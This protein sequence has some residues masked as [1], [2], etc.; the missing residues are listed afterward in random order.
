MFRKLIKD[1]FTWYLVVSIGLLYLLAIHELESFSDLGES[2]DL[3]LLSLQRLVFLGSIGIAAWHFNNRTG[4]IIFLTGLPALIWHSTMHSHEETLFSVLLELL[5]VVGAAMVIL[6]TIV[7]WQ[8]SG[9]K[10][11]VSEERYRITAEQTGIIVYDYDVPSGRIAWQGAIEAITGFTPIEFAEVDIHRW[12]TLVHPDDLQHTLDELERSRREC[13]AFH[14]EYRFRRKDD[15]Y[16]VIEESGLFLPG[17]DGLSQRMVGSMSDIT[18][19]HQAAQALERNLEL[20]NVISRLLNRSLQPGS[21]HELLDDAL[22]MLLSLPWLAAENRGAIFL[23]E[24]DPPML[25]L[26]SRHG[27][28]EEIQEFCLKVPYGHCLCGRTALSG[29]IFFS[30]DDV[31]PENIK[32]SAEP[33]GHYCVPIIYKEKV[34][35]V[36]TIYLQPGHVRNADEELFLKTVADTLANIIHAHNIM[37]EDDFH[38]NIL[39]NVRDSIIVTDNR[40]QITYWNQGAENIFGYTAT[41]MIGQMTTVLY[42]ELDMERFESG[43]EKIRQG[44]VFNEEWCGKRK[45]GT[46]VWVNVR[47][48][49]LI[50]AGKSSGGFIAVAQDISERKNAEQALQTSRERLLDAQRIAHLGNWDWDIVNDTLYWSDEIYRIFGLESGQSEPN[51]RDFLKVVHPDDRK[52]VNTAV[53]DAVKRKTPYD[54]DHRIVRPDGRVQFVHEQ[55]EVV[56]SPEGVALRMSGT[57]QDITERKQTERELQRLA[58][59]PLFSPIPILE[60]TREG[61]LSY[62]NPTTTEMFPDITLNSRSHPVIQAMLE[63]LSYL[64]GI[65]NKWVMFDVM[66][67]N[68][69]Y[70]VYVIY[71]TS[72]AHIRGYIVDITIHRQSMLL[73]TEARAAELAS[74]AKSD[75]L[76]S[77]SHEL[78]TP[79]NAIIGF[80]QVLQEEYFG[81][82]NPQQKEYLNDILS[83]G[84]HLM[85]LINDILDLSKVEAGK[86]ELEYSTV[87]LGELLDHSMVVIREKARVHTITLE[88]DIPP[89][90]ADKEIRVDERRIRQVIF[91]LLSNAA[92]FTPDGGRITLS[93]RINRHQLTV[94]VA[95]T[96]IGIEPEFHQKVFEGFFQVRSQITDKTPGT[97]LGLSLA[98]SIIELHGGRIRVDSQGRDKGST[99]SFTLPLKKTPKR[100]TD[101]K[102]NPGG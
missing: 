101:D 27:Q 77:M 57:V 96:G 46:Q 51:F 53:D 14:R 72:S 42:P 61:D 9:R 54:L 49:S 90:L 48:S 84:R 97:G 66:A 36:F 50:L 85:D 25:S 21:L 99:F 47:I 20:Q 6:R 67:N 29:Q 28:T 76:A 24:G 16:I 73:E 80:S 45:D 88:L 3:V 15:S 7:N 44:R 5:L 33:H 37:A 30:P 41:E 95:D 81:T 102:K 75:M 89:E 62:F 82:L 13:T 38:S 19:R 26:V 12:E 64:P 69:I 17:A 18:S 78:R 59:F 58:S 4:W 31:R 35:G 87:K 86:V 39:S 83:S 52:T 71:D 74:K 79:L 55:G 56:F 98:K 22:S 60:I 63:T 34:V 91:N 32:A 40:G 70:E 65:P 93:A 43:L 8:F 100:G 2:W 10:L 94:S 92:K 68:H 11:A 1:R 23:S